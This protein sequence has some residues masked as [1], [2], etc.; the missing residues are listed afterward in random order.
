[1]HKILGRESKNKHN[2]YNQAI[3]YENKKRFNFLTNIKYE[4]ENKFS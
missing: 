4:S 3:K 2:D 1:M